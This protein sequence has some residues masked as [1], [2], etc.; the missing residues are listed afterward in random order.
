[1]M[2]LRFLLSWIRGFVLIT[3]EIGFVLTLLFFA[4]RFAP[5]GPFDSG[6][7]LTQ[8]QLARLEQTYGLSGSLA[9]QYSLFLRNLFSTSKIESLSFPGQTVGEVIVQAIPVSLSVGV[10]AFMF[11][12]LLAFLL[13]V[14]HLRFQ[15]GLL[16]RMVLGVQT[17]LLSLPSFVFAGLLIAFFSMQLRLLPAALWESP[18]SI[19]LPALTLSLRP[20]GSLSILL[21][22]ELNATER[23][24]CIQTA[25]AKG[26]S[27][28]L[29]WL[30]HKL[31]IT[32]SPWLMQSALAAAQLLTGSFVVESIF[33]LPGLG[34]ILVNSVLNRDYPLTL[35]IAFFYSALLLILHHLTE[36]LHLWLDPRLRTENAST[37]ASENLWV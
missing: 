32:A 29:L 6:I 11:A 12:Q 19:V 7:G 36:K 21:T 24:P 30:R 27:E 20:A 3:L 23:M 35:G 25:R 10:S 37:Q 28:G 2:D 13:V 33:Q 17:L 34:R 1:M 16:R 26:L 8:D 22:A 9:E 5:G 15:S 14:L 18:L 31:P 4:M